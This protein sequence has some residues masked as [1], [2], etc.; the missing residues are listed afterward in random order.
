MKKPNNWTYRVSEADI[1]KI[2]RLMGCLEDTIKET[3]PHQASHSPTTLDQVK[4]YF[5]EMS[6]RALL[7][8]E[9]DNELKTYCNIDP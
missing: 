8:L 3:I 9:T 1:L 7:E 4:L 2:S 6:S 5:Y